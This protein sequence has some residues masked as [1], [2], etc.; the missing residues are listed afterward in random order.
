MYEQRR[1][2]RR[3]RRFSC[4]G[5]SASGATGFGACRREQ[6]SAGGE[7]QRGRAEARNIRVPGD[8]SRLCNWVSRAATQDEDEGELMNVR[9]A[10][11]W[12]GG[13]AGWAGRLCL[14]VDDGDDGSGCRCG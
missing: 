10:G 4:A 1:R 3:R 2:R 7:S 5:E 11:N 12:M 9:R 8:P 6:A 14:L 13:L